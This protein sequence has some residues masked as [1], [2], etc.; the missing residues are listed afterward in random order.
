MKKLLLILV[1]L[2]LVIYAQPRH[3]PDSFPGFLQLKPT[4]SVIPISDTTV[5][6]T[7]M[8][9]IPYNHFVFEKDGN[10]YKASLRIMVEVMIGDD[11]IVRDFQDEK[12]TVNSFDITQNKNVSVQG[13][14]SFNLQTDDY[15]IKGVLNDLSSDKEMKFSPEHIR[16]SNNNKKGIY[17]PIVVNLDEKDC[18]G[19]ELPLIINH[20]GS[21][22]FSSQDYQLV[23][24]IADTS[25]Q[26]LTVE[27]KNKDGDSVA[28]FLTESYTS[29]LEIS[30]CNNKLFLGKNNLRH[31]T[32]NFILRNFSN[33]LDEG[34]FILSIKRNDDNDSI[35]FPLNVEWIGKPRSLRDPEFAIEMLQYIEGSDSVI[36]KMLDVDSDEYQD[37]LIQ[38]WKK[39]D[40]TPNT[41]YNELMAEYYSRI[42]Y[43]ASEFKSLTKRNGIS[44]DRGKVYIKYGK[45][46]K[47]ERSSDEYGY[48]V[49]TWIYGNAKQR[50]VFVD[51]DGTGNF[52]LVEG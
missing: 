5:T 23:I 1:F 14:I 7:Y 20:S 34:T 33:K 16:L 51:K 26:S 28:N 37:E 42:D 30:E 31:P 40:P 49:E 46:D 32:K 12:V 38:Y 29:N 21:I 47:I 22:S 6:L 52:V 17:N 15:N 41:K 3:H 8:Y 35:N 45:P 11:L 43:A 18:N 10:N 4:I 9:R 27:L 44:S 39:Y 19:N 13:F 2:N 48:V 24:P 36:D 25:V 50:F